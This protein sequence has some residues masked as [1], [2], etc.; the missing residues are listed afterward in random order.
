M[1]RYVV[2]AEYQPENPDETLGASM[3]ILAFHGLEELELVEIERPSPGAKNGTSERVAKPGRKTKPEV[4]AGPTTSEERYC[5][6]PK[7]KIE[8]DHL[9]HEGAPSIGQQ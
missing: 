4:D 1:P 9:A 2:H 7:C 6:D 8:G 3:E 5:H